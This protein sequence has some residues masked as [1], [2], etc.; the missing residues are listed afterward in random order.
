M[1]KQELVKELE[2]KYE[3]KKLY[4]KDFERIVEWEEFVE[5][6]FRFEDTENETILEFVDIAT[7]RNSNCE[8]I[9]A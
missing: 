1:N 3:G 5:W 6:Y 2:V 9:E 4:H 7:D 8:L